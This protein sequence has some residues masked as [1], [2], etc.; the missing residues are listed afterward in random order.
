MKV[1]ETSIPDVLIIEPKV[2]GDERGFFY[3]SF[4]AAAFEAATGLKRQFVQ[5]NHSKSQRGVLRGLHYQIQQ[6][7]GKLV[8]VVAGEVFDVAVDLRK[9]SPSFG[10]W[11]GTHLSAQNQ[12]QLWIPEGFAHGF[13]VL[14]ESAEFLYKTTDYYAP[15]HERSLLWNDPELGIEWPFDEAP[16][17]S[18]KDQAGKRLSD[19]ELFP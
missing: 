13:V 16:Q 2:F 15:E 10:R 3:E 7:Q 14:S 11:F 8:R 9:S 1:V 18:A 6:P 5:D 17:L 19:A 4:N 12:H